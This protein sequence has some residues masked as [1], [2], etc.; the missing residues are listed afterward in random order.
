ARVAWRPALRAVASLLQADTIPFPSQFLLEVCL[1]LARG[2]GKFFRLRRFASA[3]EKSH[4]CL[5]LFLPGFVYIAQGQGRVFS[6]S[7]LS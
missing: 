2:R 7:A 1:H 5:S 6:A 4:L 3:G